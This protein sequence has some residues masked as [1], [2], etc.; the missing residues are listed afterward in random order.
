MITSS[1]KYVF[2]Q[3]Q[4]ILELKVKYR[5]GEDASDI[6]SWCAWLVLFPRY[7]CK[8][9]R[10][11]RSHKVCS[12]SDAK[13]DP[14]L[15][16]RGAF[17]SSFISDS[18]DAAVFLLEGGANVVRPLQMVSDPEGC[19]SE[20][21]NIGG[22]VRVIQGGTLELPAGH[23]SIQQ[24]KVRRAVG[25]LA[26]PSQDLVLKLD[27]FRSGRSVAPQISLETPI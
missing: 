2:E 23:K 1:S 13:A 5:S 15:E 7:Q 25:L 9:P 26:K 20:S 10:G 8:C 4:G 17:D 27:A 21:A 3:E 18:S 19:L 22:C 6:S 14:T 12:S 16:E 11:H 24:S